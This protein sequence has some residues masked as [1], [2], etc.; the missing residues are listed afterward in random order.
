MGNRVR[1]LVVVLPGILGSRLV[2]RREGRA[3]PVWDLSLKTLPATL[4]ALRKAPSFTTPHPGDGVEPSGLISDPSWLP[5]WFGVD[6]YTTMVD[7]LQDRLGDQLRTFSYDWRYSNAHSARLFRDAIVP[8]LEGW[9]RGA[10]G[11]NSRLVLVCHSMG[12]LVARYFCEQLDGADL[13]RQIVTFGTPHRGSIK[14]LDALLGSPSFGGL[15]DRKQIVQAWPS[16]W[17]MLPQYPCLRRSDALVHIADSGLPIVDEP[18]FSAARQF[19]LAI[20][21]PAENRVVAG[22]SSP[23]HQLAFFGRVQTTPSTPR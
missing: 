7:V 18:R 23:Y 20:R 6:G 1:D 11:R 21:E 22:G 4:R 9:Q 19:Q 15:I 2:Y 8:E 12:G 3:K 14:A 10:G 16:V 17:E 13:T 5:D